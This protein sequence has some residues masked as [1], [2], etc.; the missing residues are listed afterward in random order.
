MDMAFLF[1]FGSAA[2]IKTELNDEKANFS[3]RVQAANSAKKGTASDKKKIVQL[4]NNANSAV[5][6]N[7]D[8]LNLWAS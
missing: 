1:E 8:A 5:P 4:Y 2:E 7:D 6:D 3:E